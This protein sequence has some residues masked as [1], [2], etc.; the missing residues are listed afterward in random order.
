MI[1]LLQTWQIFPSAG[2]LPRGCEL[3]KNL[4]FFIKCLVF[5]LRVLWLGLLC[6]FLEI[7]SILAEGWDL[8]ILWA[9]LRV[10]SGAWSALIALDR[11]RSH[12]QRSFSRSKISLVP[13]T[14]ISLIRESCTLSNSH[15][16]LNFL[17][18]V[19][20]SWK[21]SPSCCLNVKN[22]SRRM[23]MFFLGLQYSKN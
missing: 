1:F 16:E 4:H 10:S 9:C 23:V 7:F 11:V 15:L 3:S 5:W 13:H 12:S 8:R 18:S 22:M 17:N 21:F 20:K 19:T 6:F 14:I 2:H